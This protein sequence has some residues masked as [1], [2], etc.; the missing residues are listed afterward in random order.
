MAT[1]SVTEGGGGL[2]ELVRLRNSEIKGHHNFRSNIG[3]GDI[4]V[5]E[6]ECSSFYSV[7]SIVVE[8]GN[9]VI[10]HIPERL[11]RIFILMLDDRRLRKIDCW[12]TGLKRP[13][14]E[15]VWRTGGDIDHPCCCV[16]YV[17]KESRRGIRKSLRDSSSKKTTL[18][19]TD[20][21]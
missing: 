18:S 5:C 6:R 4:L 9:Q 3:I 16:F 13:G 15:G 11:G 21:R 10:G 17:L 2:V 20:H 19:E 12:T 8:R 1:A 14:P 7:V